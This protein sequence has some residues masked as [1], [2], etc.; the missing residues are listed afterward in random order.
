MDSEGYIFLKGRL[1][2]FIKLL[3]IRFSLD[4]MEKVINNAYSEGEAVCVGSDDRVIVYYTG[5]YEAE[6]LREYCIKK[7]SIKKTMIQVKYIEKIPRNESGKVLYS[8]LM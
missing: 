2:R 8:A 6:T 5:K 1:K 7:F 4:G 3:G